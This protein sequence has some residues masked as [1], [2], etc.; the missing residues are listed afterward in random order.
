MNNRVKFQIAILLYLSIFN[1][2]CVYLVLPLSGLK[3]DLGHVHSYIRGDY[4]SSIKILEE[5]LEN[6][7]PKIMFNLNSALLLTLYNKVGEYEKTITKGEQYLNDASKFYSE[8]NGN[9]DHKTLWFYDTLYKYNLELMKAY[10]YINNYDKALKYMEK[11]FI[12]NEKHNI[13]Y[14][15]LPNNVPFFSHRFFFEVYFHQ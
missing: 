2:S 3:S 8:L 13:L 12:F 1:N 14:S 6:N 5:N 7:S 10:Y 9:I 11:V 4:D 15:Q